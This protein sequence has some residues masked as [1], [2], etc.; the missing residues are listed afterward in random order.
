MGIFQ[1][2]SAIVA[3]NLNDF[4]DRFE[5]PDRMLRQAL[6][7]METLRASTSA[8]VARSLAAE[9]ILANSL[10]AEERNIEKWQAR[11]AAAVKAGDEDLARRAIVRQLDHRRSLETLDR[12]LN[13]ARAT[14]A[15]LRRQLDLL[16]DKYAAAQGRVAA[17][18]ASQAA[19]EAR[20]Q[21]GGSAVGVIGASKALA[22]F[23]HFC[24]RV[25]FAEAEAVAFVD[26]D[27]LGEDPLEFE[28]TQRE[29]EGEIEREF[30]R[31]QAVEG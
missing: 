5:R 10:A 17:L 19:A 7:E 23:E 6:R 31:L 4:V 13:E 22:R 25:E 24:R 1:R 9:R 20:R 15:S 18:A 8:A 11:A 12:Q 26:L 2:T 30:A 14:N 21:V 16:R 3:A 29:R 28:A 27:S